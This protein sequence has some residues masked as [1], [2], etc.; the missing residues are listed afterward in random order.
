MSDALAIS[1]AALAV[2]ATA[3]GAR[4][5]FTH[6]RIARNIRVRSGVLFSEL[7]TDALNPHSV[8][9][10][11]IVEYQYSIGRHASDDS[12]SEIHQVSVI[13]GKELSYWITYVYFDD[14]EVAK[15]AT[16]E[17]FRVSS[18]ITRATPVTFSG[19]DPHRLNVALVFDKP[20]TGQAFWHIRFRTPGFFNPLR[21]RG[22]DEVFVEVQDSRFEEITVTLQTPV[23]S[24][25]IE[26]R[27]TTV[28]TVVDLKN[29]LEQPAE[30]VDDSGLSRVRWHLRDPERGKYRLALQLSKDDETVPAE[31]ATRSH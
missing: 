13:E 5:V 12:L 30:L 19:E 1:T 27:A 16:L 24:W 28:E 26:A 20:V 17:E 29:Q 8:R 3:I 21:E 15:K 4:Q 7:A 22:S 2:V 31:S 10:R 11:D 18:K 9:D 25:H 14:I 23:R 6:A